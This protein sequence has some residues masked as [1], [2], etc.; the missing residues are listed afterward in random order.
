MAQIVFDIGGSN[1]RVARVENGV[2]GT[3]KK[4]PTPKEPQQAVEE[5]TTLAQELAEGESIEHVGGG[6]PG[7]ISHAGSIFR[8]PNLP[9]WEN[10]AFEKSLADRLETKVQVYNDADIGALGEARFGAG[11]GFDIVAF[12]VGGTGV[13]GSR[14]VKESI[15]QF[16]YGFEPGQYVYD[17]STD[18]TLEQLVSGRAIEKKYGVLPSQAESKVFDEL[19]PI[20]ARGLYT[21]MLFWS[22]HAIVLGGSVFLD[23][24]MFKIEALE[25]ELRALNTMF[26]ELPAIK[27]GTLGDSAGLYGAAALLTN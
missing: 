10:F 13:G 4:V 23:E 14:V 6:I 26:P 5:L 20:L 11:K 21:V 16:A 8:S 17:S 27:R 24:N 9:K 19:T 18:E 12:V 3:P 2:P 7:V 1:I 15:D 22:P 25:R